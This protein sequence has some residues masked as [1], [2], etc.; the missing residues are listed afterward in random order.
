MYWC[1]RKRGV[2]EELIRLVQATYTNASTVV[3]TAHGP[4][5]NF[6]IK[7]GL[8]QGS[9]LSPFLFI[10]AMDTVTTEYRVGLPFE[11]LFA[12]DLVIIAE[13]QEELQRRWLKW[14]ERM[15][16]QGLKVNTSKTEVLVSSTQRK[17]INIKDSKGE[18][19]NQVQSFKYL[20]SVVHEEGGS[21]H[22]VKARVTAAWSKWNDISRVIGDR[23][24]PKK[25]KV[26]LYET[27]IRP[28][29]T[30]G[31]EL[32]TLRKKEESIL[33]ATEMGMLR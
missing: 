7:V 23:R 30:Y 33:E 24:M 16:S 2:P 8:H 32:W 20:G 3:R 4:T 28:V 18:T 5:E 21:T 9:A 19:L 15:A 31:G 13:T 26:R 25:L 10:V 29:L 6:D 22:A 17:N 1:L 27:V 14:E 11:L 12:D